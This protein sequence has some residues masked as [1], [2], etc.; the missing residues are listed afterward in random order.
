METLPSAYWE[1]EQISVDE[2]EF[3]PSVFFRC[4]LQY[5]CKILCASILH[6]DWSR[7]DWVFQHEAAITPYYS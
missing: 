4:L 1:I 2:H 6:I 7:C 3:N 5:Y